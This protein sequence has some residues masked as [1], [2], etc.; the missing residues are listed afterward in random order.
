MKK[1]PKMQKIEILSCIVPF[2]STFFVAIMTMYYVKK[3]NS[4]TFRMVLT[5]IIGFGMGSCLYMLLE[6][7]NIQF[8]PMIFYIIVLTLT[9]LLLIKIQV[10]CINSRKQD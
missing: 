6:K 3:Y 9:N 7:T 5:A 1:I 8:I 10:D 2:Y 4:N